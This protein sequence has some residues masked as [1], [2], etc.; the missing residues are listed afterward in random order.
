MG[1]LYNFLDF[2]VN[3]ISPSTVAIVSL[4]SMM[5]SFS[6]VVLHILAADMMAN[7]FDGGIRVSIDNGPQLMFSYV[8]TVVSIVLV[9][10]DISARPLPL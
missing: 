4:W 7:L 9:L 1:C 5:C 2:E 8:I 10:T 6:M 3:P